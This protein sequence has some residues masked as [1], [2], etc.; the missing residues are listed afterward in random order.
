MKSTG[1]VPAPRKCFAY[2]HIRNRLFIFGGL[3]A[4][5]TYYSDV[6]CLDLDAVTDSDDGL[7]VADGTRIPVP[8]STFFADL[9]AL[10]HEAF[11]DA[12]D[13]GE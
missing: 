1:A 6:H 8:P 2:A 12:L 9:R 11:E 3:G 13:L 4:Q 5:T 10:V 7:D